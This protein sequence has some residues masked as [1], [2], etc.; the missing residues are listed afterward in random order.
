MTP[1]KH[2][3]VLVI[4]PA[5]EI[6]ADLGR[7]LG[8]RHGIRAA[9]TGADG[10]A[11]VG[12]RFP[13]VVVIGAGIPWG[14]GVEV[15]RTLRARHPDLP[16]IVVTAQR[17]VEQ[18]VSAMKLGAYDVVTIPLCK[19]GLAPVIGN[20]LESVR[21]RAEV[22]RLQARLLRDR[23]PAMVT[24][25]DA[26]RGV[27]ELV[28]RVAQS[29]ST[30]VLIVGGTGTGKE[31]IAHAI[32]SRSPLAQGPLVTV[33]CAAIPEGLIESE[34]FGHEKGAFTGATARKPGLIEGAAGGTLFLDEVGELSPG[35]QAKL[36]R[37]LE[38]GE[39]YRVG[40]TQPRQVAVR[41]VAATHRDLERLATE[42]AFRDDLYYRMAVVVLR[43]PS[44]EDRRDDILPLARSFLLRY[45]DEFGKTLT[46][47]STDGADALLGHP[48]RGNIRELKNAVERGALVAAGEEVTA[49]DLGLGRPIPD[50]RERGA[51]PPL[52][53]EGLEL[54][55]ELAR[56]EG[57]YLEAA[58]DAAGGVLSVAAR[59][60]GL[61]HHTYRYRLRRHRGGTA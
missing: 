25:S 54:E 51:L 29:R 14:E 30:P 20:A 10:L 38:S 49:R 33:N 43:V 11:A 46:D 35:A 19:E 45:A 18:A 24:E 1:L 13:D 2:S 60:L 44:L 61:N 8:P 26:I 42:G 37:F 7:G 50:R 34:L 40:G 59:L 52:P 17:A 6:G 41:L 3:D 58:L 48:W 32:H 12:R 9:A 57:H 15:L 36:L 56:L 53:A 39:F 21:L 23:I 27:M 28:S 31:L 5:A 22:T 55:A 47:F 4:D 16:V